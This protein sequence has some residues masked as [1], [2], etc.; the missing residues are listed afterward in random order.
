[1]FYYFII[2]LN[3]IISL[4]YH[5]FENGE[6]V[7]VLYI[8]DGVRPSFSVV[9]NADIF[10]TQPLSNS[11]ITIVDVSLTCYS[12]AIRIDLGI[13]YCLAGEFSN[14]AIVEHFN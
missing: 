12:R 9:S 10:K 13:W 14:H 4:E 5:I 8:A 11:D 1:L 3:A 2:V 6:H 7:F